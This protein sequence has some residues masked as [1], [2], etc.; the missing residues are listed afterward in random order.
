VAQTFRDW[1]LLVV[2]DGSTDRTAEII[3]SAISRDTRIRLVGSKRI[4]LVGALQRGV[5]ASRGE[6][7]ARMD[8][9]DISHPERLAE[10]MKCFAR[11]PDLALLG[12]QIQCFPEESVEGGMRRYAHW[13]NSL[14][15]PEEI[16]RS[17]FVESPFCHPSVV[18]R[19]QAYERV[20]GYVDDGL[21]EDYGL[22]LRFDRNR[23][24]MA[25]V[26]RVLFY[27]RESALRLTRTDPR[28]GRDRFMELKLQNL[29]QGPLLSRKAVVI[30]GAGKEGRK[31]QKALQLRNIQTRHFIDVDPRKI[32]EGVRGVPVYGPDAESCGSGCLILAAV[33][34]VGIRDRIRQ[35]LFGLG[36]KERR[37]FI[38]II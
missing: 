2:D 24:P 26:P 10:Q 4:G 19:K 5:A 32:A 3:R 31:W 16:R 36:L 34:T 29:L 38:C 28:Y 13:L 8:A 7:L 1:E 30:W 18:M 27:W 37:H 21:P 23:L 15:T 25:K 12:T 17:I 22:W 20:G 9:D 6:Y 33:G 11:D 35:Y 14:S